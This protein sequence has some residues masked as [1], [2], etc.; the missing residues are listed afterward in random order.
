MIRSPVLAGAAA[1]VALPAFAFNV[2]QLN[3]RSIPPAALTSNAQSSSS[4]LPVRGPRS[5]LQGQY[6]SN[7][8][9][10]HAFQSL[11]VYHTLRLTARSSTLTARRGHLCRKP[12]TLPKAYD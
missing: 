2:R 12:T 6:R 11:D 9:Q 5:S 10:N 4:C 8:D 1:L 3:R 7:Y